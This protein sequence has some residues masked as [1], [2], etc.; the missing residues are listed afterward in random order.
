MKYLAVLLLGLSLSGGA[1]AEDELP[2][3]PRVAVNTNI[4][5]FTIELYTSRAPLSVRNFLDYV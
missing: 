3:Y 2:P 5:D 4:G 1:V